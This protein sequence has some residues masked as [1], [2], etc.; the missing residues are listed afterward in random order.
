M[1]Y[2]DHEISYKLLLTKG[3][4]KAGPRTL[5]ALEDIACNEIALAKS[6][7]GTVFA[8]TAWTTGLK[9]DI[10][11]PMRNEVKSKIAGEIASTATKK[12]WI[13]ETAIRAA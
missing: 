9:T 3:A 7:G 12:T 11:R 2:R 5:L 13:P 4:Q 1:L 8:V 6:S 10:T